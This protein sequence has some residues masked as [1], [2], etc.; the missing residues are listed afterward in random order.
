MVSGSFIYTSLQQV[1]KLGTCTSLPLLQLLVFHRPESLTLETLFPQSFV[2]LKPQCQEKH[3]QT[4]YQMLRVI[5]PLDH[6]LFSNEGSHIYICISNSEHKNM[7]IYLFGSSFQQTTRSHVFRQELQTAQ[8]CSRKESS[9]GT[10]QNCD[11]MCLQKIFP[12]MT[13][14][15]K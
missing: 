7:Q 3:L 2:F 12:L 9:S 11:F 15:V 14:N 10:Q 4:T 13:L 8:M 1:I 5:F 6:H